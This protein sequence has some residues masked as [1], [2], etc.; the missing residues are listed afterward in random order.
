MVLTVRGDIVARVQ[1]PD[2]SKQVEPKLAGI[3]DAL[4][5]GYRIETG[6]AIE[7]SVKANGALI[8]VFPVMAVGI[9]GLLMGQLQSFSPLALVFL[10]APP[11]LIGATPALLS[12]DPPFASLG[13]P[14][15]HHPP[16]RITS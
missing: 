15:H 16:P 12:F 9:L 13:P 1:A 8:A 4:P 7:E 5:Y 14:R 2:V 3:K 6:G 10:T 11:R